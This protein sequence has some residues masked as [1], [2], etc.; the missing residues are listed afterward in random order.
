VLARLRGEVDSSNAGELL[1]ALSGAMPGDAHAL[2]LD[3]GKVSYLDSAGVE[4]VFTLADRLR[5][6][7]QRLGLLVPRG[8]PVER[9][10]EISSV[11]GATELAP[12][13]EALLELLRV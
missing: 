1:T 6:R 3:L 4:L 9:V 8:A 10:L 12:T 7:R 5:T 2:A 11:A 13:E